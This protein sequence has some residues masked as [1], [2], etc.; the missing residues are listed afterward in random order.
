MNVLPGLYEIRGHLLTDQELADMRHWLADSAC[1]GATDVA[2]LSDS[3]VV[4]GVERYYP[5]GAK[6][7]LVELEV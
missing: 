5:G 4:W 7:F 6:R 1:T 2:G 3:D